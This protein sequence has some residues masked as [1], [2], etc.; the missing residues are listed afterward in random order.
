MWC[1]VQSFSTK[2]QWSQC[3]QLMKWHQLW[4]M[5]TVSTTEGY[6]RYKHALCWSLQLYKTVTM[7]FYCNKVTTVCDYH[8]CKRDVWCRDR[9]QTET[10]EWRYWDETK[11]SVPPVRPDDVQNDVSRRSVETFKPWLLLIRAFTTSTVY[12]VAPSIYRHILVI[13]YPR[14]HEDAGPLL[15]YVV[16]GLLQC[17][18]C[19]VAEVHNWHFTACA[20][21]SSSYRHKHWQIRPWPVESTSRPVA[22]A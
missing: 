4:P 22:L 6:L 10:L 11:T 9:D 3:H 19:R 17:S 20:E 2:Q 21:C 14:R 12:C 18:S 1:L 7:K 13:W 5:F 8:G 16:C 15:H